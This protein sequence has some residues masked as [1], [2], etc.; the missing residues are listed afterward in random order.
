[1]RMRGLLREIGRD[2][3]S[4][5]SGF[6]PY[7]VLFAIFL[8]V[9][10][11]ADHVTVKQQIDSAWHY[12]QSG[13]ST[14]ILSSKGLVDP[15]A[16]SALDHVPRVRAT[17]ALKDTGEKVTLTQLPG[18]PVQKYEVSDGFMTLLNGEVSQ[19]TGVFIPREIASE[20]GVGL[21]DEI[22]TQQGTM[23]VAGIYDY[24]DDGRRPGL[25]YAVLVPTAQREGFDECWVDA[26]PEIESIRSLLLTTFTPEGEPDMSIDQLNTSLGA[27]FDGPGLF[28]SR[29]TRYIPFLALVFGFFLAFISLRARKLHFASA[30]HV[31][32]SFSATMIIAVAEVFL[33]AAGGAVIAG[34][35]AAIVDGSLTGAAALSQLNLHLLTIFAAVLGAVSGAIAGTASIREKSLFKFFKSR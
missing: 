2:T 4:G 10:I 22:P 1:M 7:T 27:S 16:C 9:L 32:V 6:I 25:G 23:K 29:I 8:V 35:V 30:R 12:Q 13:A 11:V 17:G 15:V 33:W 5:S 20:L 31:G 3:V 18:A 24:P 34:L 19:E 21:R 28:Q 14:V 26:W